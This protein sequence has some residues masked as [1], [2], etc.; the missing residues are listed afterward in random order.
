MHAMLR[1]AAS[2]IHYLCREDVADVLGLLGREAAGA[3]GVAPQVLAP[4]A[5]PP[6]RQA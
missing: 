3:A 5:D 4:A 2:G 1:K 6:L